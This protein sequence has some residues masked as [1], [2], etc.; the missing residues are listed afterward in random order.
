VAFGGVVYA[1]FS[2][3]PAMA[4]GASLAAALALAAGWQLTPAKNRALGDCHRPSP[5]PPRGWRATAGVIRFGLWSGF[6]CLRSCWAMM[7]AMAV[8]SSMA[9]I[10]MA[11]IT[12]IVMVERFA[13][14]PH[15]T[16]RAVA[17]VLA[18]CALVVALEAVAA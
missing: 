2:R 7:I 17:G 8:T 15:R 18:L 3:G 13:Q 12:G 11:G 6:A 4:G 16:A 14:R 5:L 9:I 10:W 1:A